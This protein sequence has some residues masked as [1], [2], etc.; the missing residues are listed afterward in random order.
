MQRVVSAEVPDCPSLFTLGSGNRVRTTGRGSTEERY[1]LTL[2]CGHPGYEHAWNDATYDLD[3]PKDWYI[4]IAPYARLVFRMLQLAAPVAAAIDIAALPA[5]NQDDAKVR[6]EVMQAI[7]DNLPT[8][9]VELTDREF[10][11]REGGPGKLTPAE[12][13][14]LRAVRQI[15]FENDPLHAFGD[16]RRVQ[17]PSGEL[18]WVCPIH[19]REYD[20]GL[21]VLP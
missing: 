15:I 19:Y 3:P 7:I 14:A 13:Q 12:G 6:L 8:D 1:Q 18:L 16:M 17:A 10:V 9:A 2:W 4:K 11:G 20:P 5:A 21:P